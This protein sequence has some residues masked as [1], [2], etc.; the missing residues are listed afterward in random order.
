MFEIR[1]H[2]DP[3]IDLIR[4]P[5]YFSPC[6]LSEAFS[7]G[8]SS[9]NHWFRTRLMQIAILNVNLWF[10]RMIVL[11]H[12]RH[13]RLI[14]ETMTMKRSKWRLKIWAL[15]GGEL[16]NWAEKNGFCTLSLLSVYFLRHHVR[17]NLTFH[18]SHLIFYFSFR[19]DPS[20]FLLGSYHQFRGCLRFSFIFHQCLFLLGNFSHLVRRFS[21]SKHFNMI[22][23]LHFSVITSGLRGLIFSITSTNL[24]QR[25]RNRLFSSIMKQDVAFFDQT[26]TGE[27]TSRLSSDITTVG[28]AV[29]VNLNI[30]LRSGIQTSNV[31]NR[32][33]VY[34]TFILQNFQLVS[35][36]WCWFSHG[37][38]LFS[39]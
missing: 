22:G 30:F 7:S 18:A 31:H 16:S 17:F 15:L 33:E 2:Q 32:I 20:A 35:L 13:R 6:Y 34:F 10:L 19:W 24:I 38:S 27:I 36:W 1:P 4:W 39:H 3:S 11:H 5:W 23:N 8:L 37:I 26:K 21:S 12:R 25:L 9:F 28:E 14:R 29:S